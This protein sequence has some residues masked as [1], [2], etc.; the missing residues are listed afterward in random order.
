MHLWEGGYM[1]AAGN[2][3]KV[4][5]RGVKFPLTPGHEISGVIEAIGESVLHVQTGDN[6]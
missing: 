2:F 6:G 4:E 5:D 1:G 3:M